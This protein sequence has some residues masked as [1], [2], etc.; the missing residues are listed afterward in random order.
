[1]T[2]LHTTKFGGNSANQSKFI[3]ILAVRRGQTS[4]MHKSFIH[5][6]MSFVHTGRT[7][8]QPK[9]PLN[10]EFQCTEQSGSTLD[11]ESLRQVGWYLEHEHEIGRVTSR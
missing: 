6:F 3:S 7:F 8:H 10:L 5:L 9:L 11:P 1:M 2:H 4:T